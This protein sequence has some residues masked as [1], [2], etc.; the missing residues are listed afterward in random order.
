MEG[1]AAVARSV[2]GRKESHSMNILNSLARKIKPLLALDERPNG[3]SRRNLL[4]GGLAVLAT[5]EQSESRAAPPTTSTRFLINRLTM[6]WT[7]EEQALADSLGYH[8]YLE[9]HLNYAA[10][11][12]SAL[13]PRL[14]PYYTLNQPPYQ[15]IGSTSSVV[16]NQLIEATL[17]RAVYSKRQLFERMVE[18]W[19]DHFNIFI[20]KA[21]IPW[22]KTVDDRDVIRTHALGNFHDLLVASA[23][24]PAMLQYLDNAES[25]AGNPN[26]NYA[27]ELMELHTMGVS[28]GYTQQDVVE[29][30]R[31]FT[32]WSVDDSNTNTQDTFVFRS[33]LHDD[34]SKLVLGTAIPAGGGINDA[35]MVL[36]ILAHHSS[37]AHFIATKLCKRFYGYSPPTSLV[38]SVAATF[39]SSNLDI[40][41]T[42]RT[43]INAI[44]PATAPLKLKRP[45]HLVVSGMRTTRAELAGDPAALTSELRT[46]LS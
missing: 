12:D 7:P 33:G 18:F 5:L 39:T 2:G 37:T 25:V 16:T 28:G 43:L 30:A 31:C 24:S 26:E 10:I 15:L 45:F 27:R 13:A 19:T 32:G 20:N 34:T 4:W 35:M 3:L 42:L 11:D 9:Y 17:L 36:D 29:V 22:I 46:I 44:D 38:D 14:A 21:D 41:A 40:K 23:M 6:G 1:Q 8:G